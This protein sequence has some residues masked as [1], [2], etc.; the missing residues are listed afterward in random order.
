MVAAL[1]LPGAAELAAQPQLKNG[2][3]AIVNESVITYQDVERLTASQLE[4]I[5]STYRFQPELMEQKRRKVLEEGLEQLVERQ[6]VLDD[7]KSQGGVLPESVVEEEIRDRIRRMFHGDR[8]LMIRTLQAQGK[9][10]ETLR[11]EIHEDIVFNWMRQRNISTALIVSPTKIEQYYQTNQALYR[12][13]EQIKL[14]MIVLNRSSA[15]SA[16][17]MRALAQ[18]ILA[19]IGAG[20]PFAEMASIYSEGRERRDGGDWG[21]IERSKLNKGLSDV[22]FSLTLDQPSPV[23]ALSREAD[24][25]YWISLYAADGQITSARKYTSRDVFVEERK[26][27]APKDLPPAQEVYLMMAEDHRHAHTRPLEEVRDQIDR[28]LLVQEHERLRK[29]WIERLKA[30]S[31]VRY[32]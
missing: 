20:A 16:E 13:G 28:D 32:F 26:N 14:R 12:V 3:M 30:K 31:Y 22:A 8:A 21:W 2:L 11:Q 9:T 15:D 18:E 5:R 25:S 24:D 6:L 1:W 19:Q 27:A 29:K 10:L 17:D 4:A 23:V 7:F